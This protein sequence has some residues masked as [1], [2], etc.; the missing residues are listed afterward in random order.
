MK[1]PY[2]KGLE[3]AGAAFV[4]TFV[5][6]AFLM[7]LTPLGLVLTWGGLFLLSAVVSILTG[8]F[9]CDRAH[10]RELGDNLSL[11]ELELKK[12]KEKK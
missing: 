3:S 4:V 11:L 5:V 10:I 2:R 1:P 12:L 9:A 6:C 8:L 7:L